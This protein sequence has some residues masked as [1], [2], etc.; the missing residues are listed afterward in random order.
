MS[1]QQ[2]VLRIVIHVVNA[3][4]LAALLA[5]LFFAPAANAALV[6]TP[7]AGVSLALVEGA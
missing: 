5:Y 1:T 4:L 6:I 3:L 2:F 7:E